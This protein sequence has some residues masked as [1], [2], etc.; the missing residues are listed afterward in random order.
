M[1]TR[2]RT[3]Q[4]KAKM[5][6]ELV[7]HCGKTLEVSVPKKGWQL[8]LVAVALAEGW[9]L[10]RYD[11]EWGKNIEAKCSTCRIVP[12]ACQCQCRDC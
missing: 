6:T 12:H 10:D 9:T 8:S 5:T 4:S 1:T 2:I 11:L 3:S 7:C